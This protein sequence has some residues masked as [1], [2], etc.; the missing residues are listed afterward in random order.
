MSLENISLNFWL[1]S[2]WSTYSTHARAEYRVATCM[3]GGLAYLA[4]TC[5]HACP[6]PCAV[7]I[8]R[9]ILTITRLDNGTFEYIRKELFLFY[10]LRSGLL[11]KTIGI[12]R[13]Y[14]PQQRE[15]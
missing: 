14:G 4:F 12:C 10:H 7:E 3:I 2:T 9:L 8:L 6:R 13:N 5:S 1:M 11:S 15:P